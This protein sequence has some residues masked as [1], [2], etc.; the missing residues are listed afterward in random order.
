MAQVT[1]WR[2]FRATYAVLA[3]LMAPLVVSVHSIVGL[4]FAGAQTTGWHSTQFPPFFVFGAIHSGFAVVLMLVLPLRPLM[5][6]SPYITLRHLDILGKLMLTTAFC[7]GYAYTMDAFSTFYGQDR[8]EL[9]W[10][11]DRL[12]GFYGPVYWA[13]IL[14]NV[15]VPQ[16]LWSTRIRRNL[17]L[18]GLIAVGVFVGMWLERFDIVVD[19]LHRTKLPSS[20]GLYMPTFWDWSVFAGTL[21]LFMTGFLLFA[22]LLPV[23]SMYEMRELL[24]KRQ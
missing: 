17:W 24:R 9:I 19:S 16:L 23:I 20:W 2:H 3:A 7:V 10:F 1:E 15:V 21:G 11:H 8:S 6:L 18:L 5:G 4:D 14:L 12:F 13:T 22:R